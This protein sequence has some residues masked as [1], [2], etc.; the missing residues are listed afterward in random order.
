MNNELLL[1]DLSSLARPIWE[2]ATSGTGSS[3]AR[4]SVATEV[5]NRVQAL[6]VTHPH[7]AICC[8]SGKCFRHDLLPSYKGTRPERDAAMLHQF[9]LAEEQLKRAGFPVW[10]VAGFEADDV[11]ASACGQ[12]L[13][14]DGDVLIAS[15]DKD[16]LQLVGPKVRV[17]SL[18][19]G[20]VLD[21][22]AVVAKLGVRSSQVLDYL[23]L[24]GDASDNVQG[25][26]GIGPKRA[27]ELL[28]KWQ[29]IK[30]L[31]QAI[32]AD[33]HHDLTDG[34]IASLTEF[35]TRWPLVRQVLSL[36]A[37]VEIPFHEITVERQAPA[38]EASVNE[39]TTVDGATVSGGEP[40]RQ[41]VV[42]GAAELEQRQ[43]E[44][45]E[46]PGPS[47]QH[48]PVSL[49]PRV[50]VEWD[51]QLE[52]RSMSEAKDLARM[53]FD[54][55]LFAAYGTPQGVLAVILSGREIGLP[56]MASLRAFHIMDGKSS[57]SAATIVATVI[58]SGKS[59]YFRCTERTNEQATFVTQRGD[60]PPMSLT[61]TIAD[62]KLAWS[63]GAEK[64]A[65]SG[66]TKNPA[67][68]VVARASSKLARLV[69]PDVV[70]GFYSPEE[71]E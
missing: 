49:S 54:S 70:G 45:G 44:P 60:D 32:D 71:L 67:D 37:D 38:M 11:I 48:A 58:K 47:T 35:R 27:V 6:A 63:K 8:D 52:P 15:S 57:P 20:D 62:G 22:A 40:V 14:C 51:K 7:A 2:A 41:T 9:Q 55:R 36:R 13:A 24:V 46:S 18:R 39:T 53:L 56:A 5:V 25:A 17:K 50:D 64:W 59:R 21:E 65:T 66:W 69:Y 12:A 29:T 26:K 42:G 30:N 23:S 61:F 16:L 28:T 34:I 10:K 4:A 31:Y 19:T 68:M 1:I 43:V 33:T 3:A